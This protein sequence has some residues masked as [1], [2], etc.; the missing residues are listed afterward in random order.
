MQREQTSPR[1]ESDSRIF[2][3]IKQRTIVGPVLQVR[4]IMC[5]GIYGIEIQI[6]STISRKKTSWVVICR[7]HSRY[8]E[9]LP[10]LEPGPDPTSMELLRESLLQRKPTLLLQTNPASR[11]LMRC[12]NLFLR[13]P[14]ALRKIRFPWDTESGVTFLPTTG[15][16]KMLF[17]PKSQN[18]S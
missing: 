9:E 12:R 6:L 7:G 18:W 14:S 13:I 5:L 3:A 8:V 16:R 15:T 10:D 4:I 1:A 17:Q 2:A 11:K